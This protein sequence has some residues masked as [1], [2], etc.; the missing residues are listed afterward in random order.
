MI[1]DLS[2]PVGKSVN[3]FIDIKT[4]PLKL[5]SV[6]DAVRL[7]V[8]TGKDALMA[9]LDIRSAARLI[10]VC[11]PD[12]ELFGYKSKEN[13]Y[14]DLVLPFECCS[15]PLPLRLFFARR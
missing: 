15:Y 13:Y 8:Q 10:L 2:R 3:D 14:F 9:K 12:W 7:L 1:L 11:Q 5:C 4:F 6:D